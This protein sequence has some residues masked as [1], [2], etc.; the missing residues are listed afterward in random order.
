MGSTFILICIGLVY[1]I[2]KVLLERHLASIEKKQ[3]RYPLENLAFARGCSAYDIFQA[4]AEKWNFSQYKLE[5]DFKGYLKN[6][7]IPSYVH[8]YCRHDRFAND[9]TYQKILFSGGPPPLL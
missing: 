3:N 7:Q 6:G 5:Q 2:G 1:V 8:E 4:A 9:R